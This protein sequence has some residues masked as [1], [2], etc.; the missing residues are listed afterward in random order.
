[1]KIKVLFFILGLNFSVFSQS[2]IIKPIDSADLSEERKVFEAFAKVFCGI[3]TKNEIFEEILKES[4]LL[5]EK[6]YADNLQT[7]IFFHALFEEEVVGYISCDLLPGYHIHVRQL[8]V[9]PKF[10]TAGLI[11]ELLFA[12]FE[13]YPKTN[14]ITV[15][16]L[17]GCFEMLEIFKG[18]GFTKIEPI[19]RQSLQVCVN[20]EL[21]VGSKCKICELLYP[22]IW[23]DEQTDELEEVQ[24]GQNHETALEY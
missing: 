8:M 19:L 13:N 4:F 9:N 23:E 7:A 10:F 17:A 6:D 3:D 12:V 11:K 22:N 2:L 20:Y 24:N 16:C 15:S 14:L 5:E 1:M 21:K 18:L